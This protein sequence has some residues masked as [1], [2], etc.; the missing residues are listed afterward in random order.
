MTTSKDSTDL[1]CSRGGFGVAAAP[2][3]GASALASPPPPCCGRVGSNVR[4]SKG[5]RKNVEPVVH[6]SVFPSRDHEK[7]SAPMSVIC[8][9][10]TA[11]ENKLVL[12]ASPPT[13]GTAVT[14]S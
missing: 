2:A 9:V 14:N 7:L 11:G 5:R 3:A 4:L 13:C 12:G 6:V 8:T 1:S 10:G